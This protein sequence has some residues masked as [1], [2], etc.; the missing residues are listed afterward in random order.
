MCENNR[1]N[2]NESFDSEVSDPYCVAD[3]PYVVTFQDITSAS[4][5]IKS[6][7]ECTP[8]KVSR[9]YLNFIWQRLIVKNKFPEIP[10]H[11]Q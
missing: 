7:I 9:N 3:K 10:F 8:C 6:G 5:L 2:N 4:F 11:L 1:L